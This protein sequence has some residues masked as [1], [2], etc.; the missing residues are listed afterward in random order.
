MQQYTRLCSLLTQN[1]R[2]GNS[3]LLLILKEE[4]LKATTE[5]L[6][7]ARKKGE[8]AGTKLLIPMMMM[9]AVVMILIMIPAYRSF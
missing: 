5:R 2:K 3:E 7:Q 9:L 8:Q 4:A 1:I 6:D